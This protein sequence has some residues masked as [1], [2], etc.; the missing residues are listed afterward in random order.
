LNEGFATMTIREPFFAH[1]F[2][3]TCHYKTTTSVNCTL[4]NKPISIVGDKAA[5][6]FPRCLASHALKAQK[7]IAAVPHKYDNG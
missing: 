7:V 2:L 3:R 1:S 6:F 4:F 5:V